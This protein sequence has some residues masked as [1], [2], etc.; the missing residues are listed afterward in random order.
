MAMAA[1][2]ARTGVALQIALSVQ[3]MRERASKVRVMVSSSK[4]SALKTLTVEMEVT[5]WSI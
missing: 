2:C 3:A 4:A 1:S 5:V